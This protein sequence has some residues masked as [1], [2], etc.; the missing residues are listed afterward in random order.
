MAKMRVVSDWTPGQPLARLEIDGELLVLKAGRITSGYRVRVRG[1]DL[2]VT[3]MSPRMHALAG[4]MP[5][6]LPHVA[7]KLN[8]GIWTKEAEQAL[9]QTAG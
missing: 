8:N 3:V 2:D 9:L 5:E 4:H 6:K 7:A 1:A